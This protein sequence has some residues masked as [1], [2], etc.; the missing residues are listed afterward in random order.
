MGGVAATVNP[1]LPQVVP[2]SQA[3]GVQDFDIPEEHGFTHFYSQVALGALALVGF[4]AAGTRWFR[5]VTPGAEARRFEMPNLADVQEPKLAVAAY[6]GEKDDGNSVAAA[7]AAA[8]AAIVMAA[9]IAPANAMIDYKG[10]EFLGGSDK[11]DIN[12]A[13]IQAYRQFPGM[14]PTAAGLITS[15]GPYKE[16]QD[17][18]NIKK[19]QG[20][21]EIK[22][23][24][25]KYEANFVCLPASPAYFLDRTN[26]GMYR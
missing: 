5:K 12:N 22:E 19:L 24:F 16:V 7:A 21:E 18:Y 14:Y 9:S 26:N 8:S 20:K 2:A 15:N 10:I 4:A 25:K 6:S 3:Q 17:I 23:L 13:N 1:G 11:V